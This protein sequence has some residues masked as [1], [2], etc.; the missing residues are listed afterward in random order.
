MKAKDETV[1]KFGSLAA[2]GYISESQN[3]A[4]YTKY[5]KLPTGG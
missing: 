2:L 5:L 3:G 4:S 1:Q